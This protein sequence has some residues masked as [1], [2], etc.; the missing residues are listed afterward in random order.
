M[1]KI[2]KLELGILFFIA[3]YLQFTSVNVS[4]SLGQIYVG[5]IILSAVFIVLDPKR[6]IPLKR[7][8]N[9]TFGAIMKGAGAYVVLIVVGNYIIVP[10]INAVKNLISSTTPALANNAALNAFNFSVVIPYAETLFFFCVGADILASVFNVKINKNNLKKLGLWAIII[11]ISLIFMLFHLTAK[12]VSATDT[13]ALVFFMAVIS[14]LLVVWDE[15][16]ES[17][18][19]FHI[20]ANSVAIFL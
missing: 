15:S 19:F 14:L 1:E 17:A 18:L 10:G 3:V 7:S 2:T 20:L 13:L 5:F 12:S 4:Q 16:Y 8:N 9:D 6:S 11:G